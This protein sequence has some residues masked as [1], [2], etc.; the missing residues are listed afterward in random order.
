MKEMIKLGEDIK[1]AIVNM[2]AQ[3]CNRKPQHNGETWKCVKKKKKNHKALLEMKTT[4]SKIKM[5]LVGIQSR[6]TT[7][8][9]NIRKLKDTEIKLP[10][11]GDRKR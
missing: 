8:K 7:V 1:R 4:T 2:S 11:K 3:Q 10:K 5:T 9:G 6:L